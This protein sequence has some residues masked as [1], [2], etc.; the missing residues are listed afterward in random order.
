MRRMRA[1]TV[2]K[3]TGSSCAARGAE[4]FGAG[5]DRVDAGRADHRLGR[6][7]AGMEGIAAQ[8]LPLEQRHPEAEADRP[9]GRRQA[10]GAA[11]DDHE[12]VQRLGRGILPVVGPYAL[13]QLLFV[14]VGRAW[15][16]S[17]P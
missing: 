12:V 16:T 14:E 8:P 4:V 3:S 6:N 2:W 15:S 1:M 7:G 5:H 13:Q 10:G 9:F 17:E 11:T